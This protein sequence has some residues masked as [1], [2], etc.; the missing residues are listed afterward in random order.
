MQGWRDYVEEPGEPT[1]NPVVIASGC[2]EHANI[3]AIYAVDS[4]QVTRSMTRVD[5]SGIVA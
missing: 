4:R 1:V 2:S 5:E 3:C